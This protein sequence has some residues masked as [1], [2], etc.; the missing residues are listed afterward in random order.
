MT[1]KLLAPCALGSTVVA[2]TLS[3]PAHASYRDGALGFFI[4]LY[5]VPVAIGAIFCTL[6]LWSLQAFRRGWVLILD[7]ALF[8]GAALVAAWLTLSAHDPTSLLT[9]VIG[10]SVFLVPVLLPGVL[11]YSRS[12]KREASNGYGE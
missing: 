12:R 3:A 11:Q 5:S 9:V 2:L 10:E 7:A 4:M 1:L 6:L 8:V